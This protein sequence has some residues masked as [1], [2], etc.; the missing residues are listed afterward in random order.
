MRRT[1]QTNN[2]T[3]PGAILLCVVTVLCAA[4]WVRA[5]DV[6]VAAAGRRA[7]RY[8]S[9]KIR[10]Y[11]AGHLIFLGR[12]GGAVLKPLTD[13]ARIQVDGQDELNHAE[14]R[15]ADGKFSEAAKVYQTLLDTDDPDWIAPF[16]H[17]RLVVCADQTGHFAQAIASWVELLK[18]WP[19]HA[20][21]Q[22]PAKIGPKGSEANKQ[23]LAMLDSVLKT[24]LRPEAVQ[25]AKEMQLAL[26]KIEGDP[27]AQAAEKELM[28]QA[29]DRREPSSEGGSGA[30]DAT[31][32]EPAGGNVGILRSQASRLVQAGEFEQALPE[33]NRA[34]A[35][36]GEAQ[37]KR[38]MPSLLT[39]KATCHMALADKLAESGGVD[40]ARRH[41]V[42][43]GLAAMR[44]VAFFPENPTMI[45]CLHLAGRVHENIGQTELAYALYQECKEYAV[46][47]NQATWEKQ[48]TDALER[49][50]AK[51]SANP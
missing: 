9:V 14:T 18:V 42:S 21:A 41:Y 27:R 19:I 48:A 51:R 10:G 11:R 12:M 28:Q 35:A 50:D 8:G 43:A 44:V 45:E 49:L 3:R 4:A 6:W 16:V 22:P 20:I 36:V 47:R 17:A 1:R 15:Y 32:A 5:D 37:V 31:Q 13:V 29:A 2:V 33:I 38:Y 34:I 7:L 26:W 40:A 25:A 46:G 23:A 30:A 24:E 39:L